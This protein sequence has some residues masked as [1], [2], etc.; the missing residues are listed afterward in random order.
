MTINSTNRKAGPYSGN[1][2]TTVFPFAFRV[3]SK[4]DM[5]VIRSDATGAETPLAVDA[6]YTLSLNAN[7]SGNPGGTV[8]LPA[9]L[10]SGT[11]L[12]ITSAIP[13]LQPTDITNNGGFFPKVLNDA[14]DR[15]VIQIQQLADAV[16]RSLKTSI[17]TPDG[18]DPTLPTPV[19]YQLIGWNAT[20]TGLQNTD[21]TYSTALAT[22][23]ASSSAGKGSKLVRFIQRMT[24][25]AARWVE[26]RLADTVS[27]KD[28]GAVG[29]GINDD[30]A[31][32]NAALAAA[33]GRRVYF[34]TGVYLI[35]APLA[36]RSKTSLIGDGGKRS[37]I[38][39]SA[40]FPAGTT[41]ITNYTTTGDLNAYYD[42]DIAIVQLGFDGNNNSSR[43]GDFLAFAKARDIEIRQCAFSNHSAIVIAIGACRNVNIHHN[44][45]TGNG[46]PKPS[47]VST[48]CI[49]TDS[50]AWGT[51]YDVVVEHN[52]F[53]G[54]NWSCAYLMPT[55]GSFSF[56]TCIENG[57]SAVFSSGNG[58]ALR[59][60]GNHIEGQKR[61]NIS[62]SGIESGA[63]GIVIGG[64]V[65]AS[66]EADGIS[67]TDNSSALVSGNVIF[68]NGQ[69][70]AYFTSASGVSIISV[71]G[72][73]PDHIRISGNRIYDVQ[74]TKT[75]AY[76]I[77]VG[78][79]G[80]APT[81]V[82]I[83]DN[84]LTEQKTGGINIQAGKWGT[85]S[86]VRDNF[87]ADAALTPPVRCVAFRAPA[88][89][90][91]F[92][93]TGV[94]FRPRAIEI[95]AV[96]GGANAYQSIGTFDGIGQLTNWTAVDGAGRAAAN[97]SG[98]TIN[99]NSSAGTARCVAAVSSTDQDG[100]T[101]NFT[102]VTSRPYC[103]AKC[104]P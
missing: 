1:D 103:I 42:E 6:D 8:I 99:I 26:D 74:A 100:F 84:D 19:P 94:G 58:S 101:M 65:I 104:Y 56:N 89:T 21:P 53:I 41:A 15:I 3:F 50:G 18:V 70:P 54:N 97:I 44:R 9:A 80:S 22:D 78:G 40:S 46:R 93:V 35:G 11:T 49:W 43:T 81:R 61:S 45:F 91:A 5:L 12:T 16:S 86:Y 48:P 102:T 62:A 75:Q 38:K 51:P 13:N 85:G 25:A 69:D 24:G 52:Y 79:S 59:Y 31:A 7:Q 95:V 32:I 37:I 57:E 66:C 33:A 72:S 77:S 67:L 76:G 20:G 30:S 2:A 10:V 64:N 39:L 68:N 23:L 73:T 34:P 55:R 63:S 90:G 47:A 83:H 92:S 17:S 28:F 98:S 82:A 4:A 96:E 27:V 29:D 36:I 60:V 71:G 88:A 87:G 14:F